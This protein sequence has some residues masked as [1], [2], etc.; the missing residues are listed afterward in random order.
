MQYFTN[1]LGLDMYLNMPQIPQTDNV[2]LS[3]SFT[4]NDFQTEAIL[5]DFYFNAK[6]KENQKPEGR[7][8]NAPKSKEK[9]GPS[10]DPVTNIKK[11]DKNNQLPENKNNKKK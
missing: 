5:G 4:F 9:D 7:E 6:K 8:I 2:S 11:G 10:E 1:A 3:R